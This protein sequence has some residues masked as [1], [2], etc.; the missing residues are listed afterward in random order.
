MKDSYGICSIAGGW[1][2]VTAGMLMLTVPAEHRTQFQRL[3]YEEWEV[4]SVIALEV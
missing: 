3:I 1:E 4:P 2:S